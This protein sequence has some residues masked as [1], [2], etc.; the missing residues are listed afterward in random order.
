[1]YL[2]SIL[3]SLIFFSTLIYVLV[4]MKNSPFKDEVVDRLILGWFTTS[5]FLYILGG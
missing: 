4:E 5:M 1:M 3:N 2:L